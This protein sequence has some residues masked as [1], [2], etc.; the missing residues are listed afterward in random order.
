MCRIDELCR[1]KGS[2]TETWF[3]MWGLQQHSVNLPYMDVRMARFTYLMMYALDSA[4][5]PTQ[6]TGE[7]K[8][9]YR[10]RTYETFKLLIQDAA[11]GRALRIQQKWRNTGWGKVRHNLWET[12]VENDL[13]DIWYR[14]LHDILPTKTRLHAIRLSPSDLCPEC[15]VSDTISH[16]MVECGG[17][18]NLW[19]LVPQRLSM[20]LRNDPRFIPEEWL[21]RPQFRLW[22][23]PVWLPRLPPKVSMEALPSDQRLRLVGNYLSVL[24]V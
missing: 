11:H 3:T 22:P 10:R 21:Y 14:V 13:K 9:A 6:R 18:A 4:Y 23:I 12:P 2:P 1:R 8:R 19:T 7:S 15:N 17:G 5:V 24:D 16:R 20:I